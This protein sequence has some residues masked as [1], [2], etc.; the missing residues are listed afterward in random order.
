MRYEKCKGI[1]ARRSGDVG[2]FVPKLAPIPGNAKDAAV[3]KKQSLLRRLDGGSP[4]KR[5]V[6]DSGALSGN[7]GQVGFAGV[8]HQRII[9][10]RMAPNN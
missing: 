8:P 9:Q 6:P 4:R 3:L 5:I 10:D 2:G 1:L 7:A